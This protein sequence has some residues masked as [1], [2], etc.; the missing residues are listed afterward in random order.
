MKAKTLLIAAVMFL[1]LSA[2]AFAQ[3]TFQVGSTPVTAVVATGN[4]ERVGDITFTIASGNAGVG[5]FVITY[6]GVITGNNGAAGSQMQVCG[7]TP[8]VCS[9]VGVAGTLLGTGGNQNP[10]SIAYTNASGTGVVTVTVGTAVGTGAAVGSVFTVQGVRIAIAGTGL[11]APLT[12][13]ISATGNYVVAGQTNVVIV[14]GIQAGIKSVSGGAGSI[15]GATGAVTANSAQGAIGG[16]GY[17]DTNEGFNNA[18]VIKTAD[19]TSGVVLRFTLSKT[20]VAGLTFTFP[21]DM[22]MYAS[23]AYSSSTGGPLGGATVITQQ[24]ARVAST[25]YNTPL[26]T[27]TSLSSSSTSLSVYYMLNTKTVAGA[28]ADTYTEFAVLPITIG[29]D[30]TKLTLPMAADSYSLTVTMAP[31]QSATG[32]DALNIPRYAAAESSAVTIVNILG[33]TS[34]LLI[35]YAT[36]GAGYD[37][38]I[39]I[40]N[41]S[42]D[43]GK[44]PLN[45]G[46]SAKPNFGNMTFYFYQQQ[47]GTTAPTA[48]TYT[49]AGTSPGTGLDAS[50]NLPSG[51]MYS[52]LLSQLLAAIPSGP[53]IFN[54][55]I[56]VS[57]NFTHSHGQYVLSNFTTFS[58]GALMLVIPNGVDRS[59][60]NAEALDN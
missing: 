49:T 4:T 35:P 27:T 37:T 7:G 51:S 13:S 52:V 22:N 23:S 58:Q 56:F 5:T 3:A 41:T 53:T 20:P 26:T 1:A 43:P 34:A 19:M 57:C 6:P 10:L 18:F 44:T 25:A 60:L 14:S 48:F 47:V 32:S 31:V 54:G 39:A 50:G 24:W 29:T 30:T 36:L 55:Y 15:N 42:T 16:H 11:S 28:D 21:A 59:G 9:L 33:N 45:N 46:G 12:A 2:A 40:S 17:F 8:L 38:G